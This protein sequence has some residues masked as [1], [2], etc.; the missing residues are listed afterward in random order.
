V[1]NSSAG[2]SHYYKPEQVSLVLTILAII[3]WSISLT[4]AKLTFGFYGT[5]HSYPI[6][7]FISLG[8]LTIASFI[9]WVSKENHGKLLCA[10]LCLFILE[11]WLSPN[12]IG[13]N[14]VFATGVYGIYYPGT[15]NIIQSGHINPTYF[16]VQSWPCASI[17]TSFIEQTLGI[18]MVSIS[19]Y[20]SAVLFQFLYLLP[21]YIFFKNTIS[22]INHC[23]AA[24]WFF[25]L[26]NWT[27]QIYF[28]PQ[29]LSLFFL[30]N[31]LALLASTKFL[32]TE[33]S[34]I[35]H[36]VSI[37]LISAA[38]AVS[39]ALTS[40]FGFLILGIFWVTKNLK[41]VNLLIIIGVFIAIWSLYGATY[42][43]EYNIPK[44]FKRAF[45][46]DML[47]KYGA[48]RDNPNMSAAYV[49]TTYI[50]YIYSAIFVAITL[51]GFFLSKIF[52]D[53]NDI[54][55]L[56]IEVPALVI[57]FSML[58]GNEFWIR[59]FLFSLIP[60]AYFG[61]KLLRNKYTSIVFCTLFLIAIPLNDIAFYGNAV[62]DYMPRS[63][64]AYWHF[65][66]NDTARGRVIGGTKIVDPQY[67]S[68]ALVLGQEKRMVNLSS[69][70]EKLTYPIYIH[71]GDNE[72]N[73]NY[74][75]FNNLDYILYIKDALNN[76]NN[77]DAI[78]AN[79]DTTLY[80]SGP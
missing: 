35:F 17:L 36:H 45:D 33:Y 28:S 48:S 60:M 75:Y 23:W 66:V 55:I 78:Y 57:L 24:C 4:Q 73:F 59:S 7:Y 2:W 79:T 63:E 77:Y 49:A 51:T 18:S 31:L 46:I 44:Y 26:A 65:M 54:I 68:A 19:A 61:I 16:W 43:F 21:L 41:G 71:V 6:I 67:E 3:L 76:S 47:F 56:L 58:Y 14:P 20:W 53:K 15:E 69:K 11:I 37:I 72:V 39:H 64:N 25:Y 50:R 34:L 70:D 1:I 42:Q 5:I 9:L 12:L 30:I 22:N 74:Y 13:S 27:A 32:K 29:A 62:I 52:K 80:F 40:I 8:L 38:L 10:Q